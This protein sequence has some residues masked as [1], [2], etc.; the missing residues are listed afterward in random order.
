MTLCNFVSGR[1]R[2]K[3]YFDLESNELAWQLN[4]LS[5]GF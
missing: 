3:D 5:Y 1:Q 2:D 4:K